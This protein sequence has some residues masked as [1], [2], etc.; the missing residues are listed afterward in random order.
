[1]RDSSGR[2]VSEADETGANRKPP[3]AELHEVNSATRSLEEA[4]GHA[5]IIKNHFNFILDQLR[6]HKIYHF[7]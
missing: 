6:C 5:Q 4:E 3:A 1:M 7:F 2:L